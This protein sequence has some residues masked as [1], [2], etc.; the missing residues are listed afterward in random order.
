MLH[1]LLN[2]PMGSLGVGSAESPSAIN[3]IPWVEVEKEILSN[4]L[5]KYEPHQH[6]VVKKVLDSKDQ[7]LHIKRMFGLFTVDV[8][9]RRF[10]PWRNM[11]FLTRLEYVSLSFSLSSNTF[12]S[13]TLYFTVCDCCLGGENVLICFE[14]FKEITFPPL[15]SA[16][17]TFGDY[18]NIKNELYMFVCLGRECMWVQL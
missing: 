3:F 18:V 6:V 5:I 17:M 10:E 12:Y 8:Y 7:V 16:G 14:V 13:D 2:A 9:S 1:H 4:L 11:P 15:S